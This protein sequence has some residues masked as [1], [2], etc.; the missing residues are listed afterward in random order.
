MLSARSQPRV[1]LLLLV[2]FLQRDVLQSS[3]HMRFSLT[4]VRNFKKEE[5][6]DQVLNLG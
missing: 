1:P 5:G 2:W 4:R 6:R 3:T